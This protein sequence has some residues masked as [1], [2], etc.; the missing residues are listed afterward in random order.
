MVG[1]GGSPGVVTPRHIKTRVSGW[2][3]I[4]SRI[5]YPDK[6]NT[7]MR[8]FQELVATIKQEEGKILFPSSCVAH[9]VTEFIYPKTI[10]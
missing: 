8:Q 10:F 5:E 1:N 2:T 7:R 3:L 9:R 6:I 4:M